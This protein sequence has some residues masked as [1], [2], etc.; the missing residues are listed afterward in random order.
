MR[1]G[2]IG[3]GSIAHEIARHHEI[4]A[5]YDI[6]LGKCSDIPARV[7]VN[8]DE[9]LS[10]SDLVIE[11]A[12]PQAVR[13][14]AMR[15]VSADKDMLIMSVGGLADRE[16]REELFEEAR[17]RGTRIYLPSGAIG[18]LDIIRAAR[19][20]GLD[21]VRIRSTKNP[22]ALGVDCTE[23]TKIFEGTA[24]EA[25]RRF[26]RSTNVTVLLSIVSGMDVRVEVY[27]DPDA[28][29]NVHEIYIRGRFGEASIEVRN[30]PSER[31]PRTS[32]LAALSPISVLEFIDS[33]VIAGV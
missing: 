33:S 29:E 24:E 20:A 6:H 12:S 15:V 31:N 5:V 14:Y 19:I 23:K 8:F 3:C 21:E 13:E 16:F 26:P 1:I 32:Y 9:L 28:K 10:S 2:I 17:K 18:G 7:C 30:V 22:R 27:A 25:I 11:A 4:S